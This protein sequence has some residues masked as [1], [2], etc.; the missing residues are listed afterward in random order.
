MECD[1]LLRVKINLGIMKG[2]N[3]LSSCNLLTKVRE[4]NVN[5]LNYLKSMVCF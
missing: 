5:V 2:L 1:K 4:S 3:V